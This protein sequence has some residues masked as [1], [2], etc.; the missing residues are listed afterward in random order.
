MGVRDTAEHVWVDQLKGAS[1]VEREDAPSALLLSDG[2]T[3][4]RIRI[5]GIVVSPE[6]VVDDGTGSVLIRNFDDS[7]ALDVGDPVLVIGRPRMYEGSLYIL[8]EIAKPIDSRWLSVAQ[9]LW[10]R[11]KAP[12]DPLSVVRALDSGDG[13]DY[14]AVVERL[15]EGGEKQIVHLLAVGE[16]FETRPGKLKVLE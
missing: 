2:R 12:E 8:G 16:L 7:L 4:S 5:Y 10:P 14:D 15:G 1:F 9:K 11:K 3:V 13:A 6:L